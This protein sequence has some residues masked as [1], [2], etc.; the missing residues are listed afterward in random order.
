M[1]CRFC[2]INSGNYHYEEVDQ[3]F[4]KN[5]D[6]FAI[7]SI[8]ALVEGWSL[9]IPKKHQLSMKS[10]YQNKSFQKIVNDILPSIKKEYGNII[11]FEHGSN[12]EGSLTACG[13][14]HAHM[15][16]VPFESLYE[17]M[18]ESGLKWEKCLASEINQRI[19]DKEYLFYIDLENIVNWENP[20]GYLHV[21][22]YPISQFFRR[23]IA[24]KLGKLD[25]SNYKDFPHFEN[26]KTTQKS[27]EKLIA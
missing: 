5:T 22:D 7:A 3:P 18:I 1:E 23:L 24:T 20:E 4:I 17:N 27:L 10:C 26:S 21:L 13:T 8:G 6:F 12:K 11:A 19:N 14:D 2:N 9:V 15:H 16:L 25:V